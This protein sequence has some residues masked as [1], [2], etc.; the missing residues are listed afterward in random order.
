VRNAF[1]GTAAVGVVDHD[2]VLEERPI[3]AQSNRGEREAGE[4]V[5]FILSS[6]WLL[7]L[8]FAY[9]IAL[10]MASNTHG[11][12][13]SSD[14][15]SLHREWSLISLSVETHV[16]ASLTTFGRKASKLACLKM[17][18]RR[19]TVHITRLDSNQSPRSKRKINRKN[20]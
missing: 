7:S 6:T 14:A 10:Q 18:D 15:A 17:L 19:L 9:K 1:V 12:T 2:V 5:R 3:V 4:E 20:C 8:S 13:R 11:K 16:A